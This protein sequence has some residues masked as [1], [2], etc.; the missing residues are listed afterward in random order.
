[1]EGMNGG[2]PQFIMLNRPFKGSMGLLMGLLWTT[3]VNHGMW[4]LT[5]GMRKMLGL[6]SGEVVAAQGLKLGGCQIVPF[7]HCS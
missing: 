7:V 5:Q 6:S 4:R 1:M 2:W 3:G